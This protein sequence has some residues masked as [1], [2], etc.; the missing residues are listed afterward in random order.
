MRS[1][2]SWDDMNELIEALSPLIDR[3]QAQQQEVEQAKAE[4][5][6]WRDG[7]RN[8]QLARIALQRADEAEAK[9]EALQQ[10]NAR[11]KRDTDL[12]WQMR[13]R[14]HERLTKLLAEKEKP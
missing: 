9:V 7:T 2:R 3:E 11:L 10:E 8:G 12:F 6:H 14:R 4:A 1:A 5:R 13:A